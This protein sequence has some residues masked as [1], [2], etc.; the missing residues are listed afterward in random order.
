MTT[1]TSVLIFCVGHRVMNELAKAISENAICHS[2]SHTIRY[3]KEEVCIK[4]DISPLLY[5][6]GLSGVFHCWAD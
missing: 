6:P 2:G 1:C 5:S 3:S 4:I